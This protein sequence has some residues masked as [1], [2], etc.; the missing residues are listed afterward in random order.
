MRFA[1][2]MLML[3][4]V[5]ATPRAQDCNCPEQFNF[6]TQK[7]AANYAG[8]R[9]KVNPA[10]QAEFDAHTARYRALAAPVTSDTTCARLL[11]EWTLFSKTGTY[12]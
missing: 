7:I 8:Y 5:A 12:N 1:F 9:D 2:T 10:T 4:F 11:H 3:V 6:L